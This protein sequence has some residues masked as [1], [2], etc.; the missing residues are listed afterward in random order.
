MIWG[1]GVDSGGFQLGYGSRPN[2]EYVSVTWTALVGVLMA[3][4]LSR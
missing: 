1:C 2:N 4:T 3:I